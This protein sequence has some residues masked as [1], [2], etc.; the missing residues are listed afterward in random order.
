MNAL[1]VMDRYRKEVIQVS[2]WKNDRK[3]QYLYNIVMKDWTQI[4][5]TFLQIL[6]FLATPM[7][8][9]RSGIQ[10]ELGLQDQIY[11][12]LWCTTV[13]CNMMPTQPTW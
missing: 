9:P 11:Q 3:V 6:Q 4:I 12:Y 13:W 2:T 1:Q 8:Q 7:A 5:W 10:M